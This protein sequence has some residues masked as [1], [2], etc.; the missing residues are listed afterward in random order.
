MHYS[1]KLSY[2]YVRKIKLLLGDKY[3]HLLYQFN[4]Y[5]INLKSL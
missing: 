2:K 4:R 1:F 5:W 3:E